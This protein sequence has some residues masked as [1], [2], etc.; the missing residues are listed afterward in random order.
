MGISEVLIF[1]EVLNGWTIWWTNSPSS[2]AALGC[3]SLPTLMPGSAQ[4]ITTKSYSLKGP[5]HDFV[6]NF[7]AFIRE[8]SSKVSLTL[9]TQSLLLMQL[10]SLSLMKPNKNL[11]WQLSPQSL[12][13]RLQ[14]QFYSSTAFEYHCWLRSCLLVWLPS[15]HS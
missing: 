1:K 6:L 3:V 14:Q 10:S 5:N 13:H 15:K 8:C 12:K 11:K 2:T 7:N 9:I 4:C